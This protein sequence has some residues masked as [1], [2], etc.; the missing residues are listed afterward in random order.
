MAETDLAGIAHQNIEPK[1]GDEQD[2]RNHERFQ[3][4]TRHGQCRNYCQQSGQSDA[5][6][7]RATSRQPN[8]R[9]MDA[10]LIADVTPAQW[11][12]WK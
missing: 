9:A 2:Q 3:Q 5:E 6:N 10:T 4:S 1:H 11:T 8:Q 12:A 7:Q